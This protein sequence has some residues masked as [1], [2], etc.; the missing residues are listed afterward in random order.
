[1]RT[2]TYKTDAEVDIMTRAGSMLRT[3]L[4]EVPEHIK[5]GV[6]TNSINSFV[7]NRISELGGEPGFKKVKGYNWAT[8]ICV[9]EQVVH[10]PP[11]EK[12]I[13]E[14]DVIT[15][16]AGVFLN[17][18]H[19]DSAITVQVEPHT[20]DVTNFLETGK[21]AL[22]RALEQAIV[23]KHVGH[24]S[25]VFEDII[26]GAGYSIIPELTGHGVGKDLHED[27][28]VPCFLDRPIEK[29]IR[30]KKGMTLAIEVMYA[31]GE[32]D[33]EYEADGW[34]LRTSDKSVTA[35][36]EHTVAVRENKP[37]ILT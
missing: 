26:E 22:N 25:K 2:I 30:L 4:K 31:M 6:T 34:S 36:F 14:G 9:N 13:K 10:T 1:M 32:G 3:V 17:G 7:D 37:F 11:S 8:C 21:K 12:M 28:Y 27:P 35:C 33:I 18:F 23:G 16:D 24:I 15:V 5:P 19:T 29:T 20:P